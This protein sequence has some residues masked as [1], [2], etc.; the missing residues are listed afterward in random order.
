M[1]K[2]QAEHALSEVSMKYIR[3]LICLWAVLVSQFA[4]AELSFPIPDNITSTAD[5]LLDLDELRHRMDN[6]DEYVQDDSLELV[7]SQLNYSIDLDGYLFAACN[8]SDELEAIFEA[9]GHYK[10]RLST[11][12]IE[13]FTSCIKGVFAFSD[14]NLPFRAYGY[15]QRFDEQY[16]ER[17]ASLAYRCGY[18]SEKSLANFALAAWLHHISDVEK[19]YRFRCYGDKYSRPLGQRQEGNF[20]AGADVVMDA[21]GPYSVF[22]DW[23]LAQKYFAYRKIVRNNRQRLL[24]EDDIGLSLSDEL[25]FDEIIGLLRHT[26]C[27]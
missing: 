24:C 22:Q 16:V 4:S 27:I 23:E 5:T 15:L 9:H 6:L 3:V 19:S 13:V 1:Q 26:G 12:E 25:S 21:L 20:L 7:I 18:R 2:R 10:Y 11:E 17:V 8:K 14:Q